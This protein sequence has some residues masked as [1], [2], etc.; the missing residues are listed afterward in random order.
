[1]LSDIMKN[2]PEQPQSEHA[3]MLRLVRENSVLLQENSELL[4]KM[5]RHSVFGMT[6]K[7]IW[8]III[9]G[10]P[11]AVYFYV[12]EPYFNVFGANYETFRQEMQEIPVLRELEKLLPIL[13]N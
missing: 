9:I 2:M 1:M 8:F 10:A 6:L 12:L 11:F 3:E 7:V 4:H 5:Y 13:A